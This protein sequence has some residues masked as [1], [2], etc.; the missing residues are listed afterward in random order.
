MLEHDNKK[1]EQELARYLDQIELALPEQ[2][3]AWFCKAEQ[4]FTSVERL[5]TAYELVM[6]RPGESLSAY[7][8]ALEYLTGR[9]ASGNKRMLQRVFQS[10]ERPWV[11][12]EPELEH[13]H[14]CTRCG[15]SRAY[16]ERGV[17]EVF[18]WRVVSGRRHPQSYCRW[19]RGLRPGA[20][21]RLLE[22]GVL[23]LTTRRRATI[24]GWS[25][26]DPEERIEGTRQAFVEAAKQEQEACDG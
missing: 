12:S 22:P 15:F 4:G 1:E 3:A 23:S 26:D 9:S 6:R 19:C 13:V 17:E 5:Y 20:A 25:L 10:E 24:K 16:D 11:R 21:V 2:V 7:A 14:I 18:G 8:Q